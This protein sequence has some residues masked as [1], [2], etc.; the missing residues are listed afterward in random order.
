MEIYPVIQSQYLASLEMLKEAIVKCPEALWDHPD[1]R[2]K[3]W[4]VAFHAIFYT[5][6]YV[7]PTG[8]DFKPWEK[9][10]QNYEFLGALPWPP[11]DLPEI[12]QP[13]NRDELLAYLEFCRRQVKEILPRLSLDSDQSGFDWLPFGKLELQFYTIRHLQQHT[14]ELCERLG[15]AGIDVDWIGRMAV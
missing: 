1:A 7:Q 3:F 12:G 13:Y 8:S 14:G 4:H 11:H 15:A 2:N 5:H 6:L 9:H 10:R